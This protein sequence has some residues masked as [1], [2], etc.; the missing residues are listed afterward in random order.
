VYYSSSSRTAL[1][2]AE[3]TYKDDH[4]STSV[5]V[6]FDIDIDQP[7]ISDKLRRVLSDQPPARL[8][9]WTTTPWTLTANMV[10]WL[11]FVCPIGLNADVDKAIAVSPDC[12]YAILRQEGDSMPGVLIIA[13]DRVPALGDVLGSF[14][15][16]AEIQGTLHLLHK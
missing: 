15:K 6:S 16:L 11:V 13:N 14:S 4:V 10:N 12:V 1:A 9:V 2:E 5:Y 8:L 3:L 7:G